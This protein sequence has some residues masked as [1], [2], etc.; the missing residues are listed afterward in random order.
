MDFDDHAKNWRY[1]GEGGKHALFVGI[2][3]KQHTSRRRRR[4][5]LRIRKKDLAYSETFA[6]D[7]SAAAV[8]LATEHQEC[9]TATAKNA[10]HTNNRSH[11]VEDAIAPDHCRNNDELEYM[12]NFILPALG[13]EYVDLPKLVQLDWKFLRD[14]RYGAIHPFLSTSASSARRSSSIPESR[15]K[16]WYWSSYCK[17]RCK[18]NKMESRLTSLPA[19]FGMLL[20]DYK[21]LIMPINDVEKHVSDKEAMDSTPGTTTSITSDTAA[22]ISF[23][24]KPKGGY[25]AYSPLVSRNHSIKHEQT[26]FASLQGLFQLGH[27]DKGWIS[28]QEEKN[29]SATTKSFHIS[30]YNPLDMFSNNKERIQH[31][32]T[33]LFRNPQNNLRVFCN[34]H[35]IFGLGTKRNDDNN[36]NFED[37]GTLERILCTTFLS[38]TATSPV[39]TNEGFDC[40]HEELK[41]PVIHDILSDIVSCILVESPSSSKSTTSGD[42]TSGKGDHDT[43]PL[44][45]RILTLQQQLDIIDTDGAILIYSRLVSKYYDG[46]HE[47]AERDIDTCNSSPTGGNQSTLLLS[48]S[49]ASPFPFPHDASNTNDSCVGKTAIEAFGLQVEKFRKLL[50]RKKIN[51]MGGEQEVLVTSRTPG[52]K[53]VSSTIAPDTHEAIETEMERVREESSRLVDCFSREECIYLIQNW[54]LS[55]AMCDVSIFVTIQCL[56]YDE[57]SN[58]NLDGGA[59]ARD[60][61]WQHVVSSP[62]EAG[63]EGSSCNASSG[64][65]LVKPMTREHPGLLRWKDDK[66]SAPKLF[67]YN[68][69]VIDFDQK[70]AKKLRLRHEKEQLFR[71][72]RSKATPSN[73]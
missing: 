58:A 48:L 39:T 12:K 18:K 57:G 59:R 73:A 66:A 45:R 1:V 60:A 55:L 33:E 21:Q 53:P 28:R 3:T 43:Q 63:G 67:A 20:Y 11:S 36:G 71:H 10:Q 35:Q 56:G 2:T 8:S 68:V 37:Y 51:A 46:S 54:L 4:L 72:L 38:T 47:R 31:S 64:A 70:P 42:G 6:A 25:V 23:E 50:L 40:R 16:D 22:T 49:Q 24:I 14:L 52:T 32:M 61:Q 44:L 65:S 62:R 17:K 9:T 41:S 15:M 30:D 19:P 13:N 27:I 29:G 34:D 69:K 5:L 26:R 7:A